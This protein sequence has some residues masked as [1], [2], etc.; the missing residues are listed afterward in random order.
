[1]LSPQTHRPPSSR[2]LEKKS[3]QTINELRASVRIHEHEWFCG[4][5]NTVGREE[6]LAPARIVEENRHHLSARAC[7]RALFP[8][9]LALVSV[10]I[11]PFVVIGLT[12][13]S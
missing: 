1:M 3:A 7:D 11:Q 2:R 6:L 5:A 8:S 12:R 10:D 4:W 13:P 9:D